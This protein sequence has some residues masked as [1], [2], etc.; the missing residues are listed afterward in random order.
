[1]IFFFFLFLFVQH[2]STLL[3]TT[4]GKLLNYIKASKHDSAPDA[5]YNWKLYAAGVCAASAAV[6][7]GYD[8]AFFGTSLALTSFKREFELLPPA[9]STVRFGNM[10]ASACRRP[11][12]THDAQH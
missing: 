6:M 12:P 10:S 1:M 4:M 8:S 2:H 7:I 3:V 11:F 5:I 9:Y